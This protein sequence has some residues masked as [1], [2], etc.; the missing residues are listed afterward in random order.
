MIF[1]ENRYPLFDHALDAALE[2]ARKL[3][4]TLDQGLGA[5]GFRHPGLYVAQPGKVRFAGILAQSQLGVLQF[6][7]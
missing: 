4:K 2:P 1:P 3:A 5:V 7:K 6:P